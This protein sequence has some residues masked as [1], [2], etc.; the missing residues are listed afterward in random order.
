MRKNMS[1]IY[2]DSTN[3]NDAN[4]GISKPVKTLDRA[5]QLSSENDVCIMLPSDAPY[6]I[7]HLDKI[8]ML[9]HDITLA[10]FG[11]NTCIQTGSY[12]D[13]NKQINNYTILNCVIRTSSII[14][15]QETKIPYSGIFY[16]V[17]FD[18][19]NPNSIQAFIYTLMD[20][21]NKNNTLL[22]FTNCTFAATTTLHIEIYGNGY[23]KNCFYITKNLANNLK[24]DSSNNIR[25][26]LSDFNNDYTVS[27]YDTVGYTDYTELFSTYPEMKKL[28]KGALVKSNG[29]YYSL[30]DYDVSTKM[31]IPH[32]NIDFENDGFLYLDLF[33]E[34]TKGEETFIP[35]TKFETYQILTLLN[36]IY[37]AFGY[38]NKAELLV[39]NN[40]IN[41]SVAKNIDF[42]KLEY[43]LVNH[44]Q[45]HIALS[46]DSGKTWLTWNSNSTSFVDLNCTIPAGADFILFT[47]SE[48][49]QW[50]QAAAIIAANGITPDTFNS[51]NFNLLENAEKIRLAYVFSVGDLTDSA[52]MAK[53]EWQFDA[54]GFMKQMKPDEYDVN[55]Y[56][57]DIRF[58]S[59]IANDIIQVNT[60]L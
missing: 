28:Y 53:L 22:Y 13:S 26:S 31:Y 11:L 4:N 32:D 40:D 58:K 41:I 52:S 49:T 3:G 29:K 18:V 46:T 2:I 35:I 8:S 43:S 48:K 56:G 25:V 19:I 15:Y 1:Y 44:G 36:K 16:N 33:K 55:I 9:G 6:A 10:G 5:F 14:F 51:L 38:R 23:F 27:G 50:Y 54:A 39:A 7:E 59:L 34:T 42:L 20:H 21:N 37:A 47:D 60:M 24:D 45:L 30:N 17:V 57:K 12:L